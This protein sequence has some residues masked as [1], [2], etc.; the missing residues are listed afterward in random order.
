MTQAGWEFEGWI[1]EALREWP[2]EWKTHFVWD[3]K[4]KKNTVEVQ[5]WIDYNGQ[6]LRTDYEVNVFFVEDSE[7]IFTKDF[8]FSLVDHTKKF[9]DEQLEDWNG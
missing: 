5:A 1:A 4:P 2:I 3:Y 8:A 6:F 9:M 7:D